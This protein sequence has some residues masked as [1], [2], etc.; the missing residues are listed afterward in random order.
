M[1]RA[2][3]PTEEGPFGVTFHEN[4]VLASVFSTLDSCP[5]CGLPYQLCKNTSPSSPSAPTGIAVT[6]MVKKGLPVPLLPSC[7]APAFPNLRVMGG[8]R[9]DTWGKRKK[10]QKRKG[11]H[12]IAIKLLGTTDVRQPEA[13]SPSPPATPVRCASTSARTPQAPASPP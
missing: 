5:L 6:G 12:P 3:C 7:G 13:L 11:H 10:L 8:N 2:Y 9:K 4:G 1:L